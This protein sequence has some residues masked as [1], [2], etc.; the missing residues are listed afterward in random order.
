MI[1]IITTGGIGKHVCLSALIPKIVEKYGNFNILSPW[2]DLFHGLPGVRRSLDLNIEYGY[3]DY[4]KDNDRYALEPYN[5]NDFF[6]KRIHLIEGFARDLGLTYNPETD[7][8]MVP[9]TTSAAIAKIQEIKSK[10]KFIVVQFMGGNQAQNGKPND[11]VMVKDYP[12]QLIEQTIKL[13]KEKYPDYNIVNFGLPFEWTIDN[14]ISA[15]ELPYTAAPYLLAEAETFIAMDSMLQHFSACAGVRK[16]GVVLWGATSPVNFGYNH[17]F[18]LANEC[19]L[20]DQHC[21]RPYFQHTSDV[22]GKGNVWTCPNRGCININPES[23]VEYV[24]KILDA[25]KAAVGEDS[26]VDKI[27]TEKIEEKDVEVV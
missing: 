11:K 10:G 3:E 2:P 9:M 17:N 12:P 25:K 22:V 6:K 7:F 13:L 5:Q 8:P 23:V 4:F 24:E 16:S 15:A 21:T 27:E 19:P 26:T 18:N 20:K 1:T 14:T